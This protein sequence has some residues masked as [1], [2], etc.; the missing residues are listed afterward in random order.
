[1]R[2]L[3]PGI[4]TNR[5][6]EIDFSLVPVAIILIEFS[7]FVTQLSSTS[8]SNLS[9]LVLLRFIHTV[10]MIFISTLVS[11]SYI[12]LKRPAL[13]YRDLASTGLLV[14]AVGDILHGYLA[15]V[16]GFELISLYRRIGIITL[17]GILWFPAFI[18]VASN[19]KEIFAQ[20]KEYEQRL[21]VSTRLRSRTS[22]E[23]VELRRVIQSRIKGD[24]STACNSLKDSIT[25]IELSKQTLAENNKSMQ[26]LLSGE[27][28]RNLSRRLDHSKAS[29]KD[30]IF[31]SLNLNSLNLLVQ[32]S[33]ILY[34]SSIRIAPLPK[35]AYLLVLIALITPPYI[36]FYS[37]A[38]SLLTYPL[39]LFF[40]FIF[41][42]LV[43]RS[44]T[45]NSTRKI[46]NS[47]V[48]IYLTGLLP[49][50]ANL[51]GQLIYH[52]PQT[53]FP[54][55]ITAL[56]LPL[57]YYLTMTVFQVLRPSALSLIRN[58]EIEASSILQRKVTQVISDEFSQNLSHKWA[59][60]IH[61][62]ILTRLA[63]TSLKLEASAKNDD[64]QSFKKSIES[65]LSLLSAPDTEFEREITDLQTEVANRLKPW[66]GLLDINL[67]IDP[68]LKAIRAPRVQEIGE[69]IEE[70]I[71]NSVRHGKA[72]KMQLGL[73]RSG[74]TDLTIIA[75]D[76]AT[77]PPPVSIQRAGLGT[78][79]FN[80]A[81][82]GRWSITREG[83]STRF[84]LTMG[85]DI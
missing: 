16:L 27:H 43:I 28:L 21:I 64:L 26:I 2:T 35:I 62:K 36:Y 47:S 80:L 66:M 55:L 72:K 24:L 48:L 52:D 58:D 68:D 41:V 37:L 73:M 23:F 63:A 75:I 20:L 39:L 15:S 79:I 45:G 25:K 76:N 78:R 9:N 33:R 14:M 12:L 6:Y 19:R 69:V 4:N 31:L 46:L 84:R 51:I 7:V 83:S 65:L 53:Q 3:I 42:N 61:G 54:I 40:V 59:V 34:A 11:Q 74:Q 38:E 77:T 30:R 10:A 71:T 13:T 44:Q 70:L 50:V 85:F 22:K 1:M 32:Q 56:A 18:I 49:L 67:Q 5:K 29:I 57:T 82:D 17:Q 8:N 81:S 60:F